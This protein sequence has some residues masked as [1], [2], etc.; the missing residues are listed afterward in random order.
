MIPVGTGRFVAI[1]EKMAHVCFYQELMIANER[2]K[3]KNL[4][5]VGYMS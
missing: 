3:K 4:P 2:M 5:D 1:P